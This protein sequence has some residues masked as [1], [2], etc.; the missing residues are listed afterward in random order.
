VGY[1]RAATFNGKSG[2][3]AH[4]IVRNALSGLSGS[5]PA[6]M[7]TTTLTHAPGTVRNHR[8]T[9]CGWHGRSLLTECGSD[10][11]SRPSRHQHDK[12]VK[13]IGARMSRGFGVEL[14]ASGGKV[15]LLYI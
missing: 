2:N 15:N 13:M 6:M 3:S 5:H 1:A 10:F 12:G 9:R 8:R 4:V 7:G 14:P 11:T